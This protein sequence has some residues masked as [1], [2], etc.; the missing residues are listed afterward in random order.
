MPQQKTTA[1]DFAT[2]VLEDIAR[3]KA[4]LHGHENSDLKGLNGKVIVLAAHPDGTLER[5]H[6]L[7]FDDGRQAEVVAV[8]TEADKDGRVEYHIQ[9]TYKQ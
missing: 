6:T 5:G 3:G 7:P 2:L 4:V 8:G 9:L 1:R